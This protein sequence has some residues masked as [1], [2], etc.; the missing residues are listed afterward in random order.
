MH[1]SCPCTH[2]TTWSGSASYCC[3][4]LHGSSEGLELN[5]SSVCQTCLKLRPVKQMSETSLPLLPHLHL[6]PSLNPTACHTLLL[7]SSVLIRPF[8]SPSFNKGLSCCQSEQGFVTPGEE[9][10]WA[11]CVLFFVCL[12]MKVLLKV[13]VSHR[14]HVSQYRWVMN[15]TFASSYDIR[16]S[17]TIH[18]SLK[19]FICTLIILSVVYVFLYLAWFYVCMCIIYLPCQCVCGVCGTWQLWCFL[20]SLWRSDSESLLNSRFSRR[21]E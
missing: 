4:Q 18:F 1:N 11:P 8:I 19:M 17:D 7:L 21:H 13:T 20:S 3:L 9:L 14:N 10:R 16:Q 15:T 2:V 12:C 6:H 5:V